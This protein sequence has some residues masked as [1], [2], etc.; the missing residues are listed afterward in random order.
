MAI[1]IP[2]HLPK[3]IKFLA[4]CLPLLEI[5]VFIVI[6]KFIGVFPTVLLILLSTCLGFYVLK[7]QGIAAMRQMQSDFHQQIKADT[8]TS[9]L[10]IVAGVLLII[11]GFITSAIGLVLLIPF[12][13]KH[14]IKWISEH[15]ITKSSSK[16]DVLEGEYWTTKDKSSTD[17]DRLPK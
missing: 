7:M 8:L 9:F 15:N 17:H 16:G 6:G 2:M 5:A 3:L 1:V 14:C 11:P 13:Q 10:R 4:L 12:V